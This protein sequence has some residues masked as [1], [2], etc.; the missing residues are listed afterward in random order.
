MASR[1]Q[2]SIRQADADY[3]LRNANNQPPIGV[4]E[5]CKITAVVDFDRLRGKGQSG[6]LARW[7]GRGAATSKHPLHPPRPSLRHFLRPPQD[8][9]EPQP[10]QPAPTRSTFRASVSQRDRPEHTIVHRTVRRS[11][12]GP[13]CPTASSLSTFLPIARLAAEQTT[14][15]E[16]TIFDMPVHSFMLAPLNVVVADHSLNDLHAESSRSNRKLNIA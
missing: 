16:A 14:Y 11:R 9:T 4:H 2:G 10:V 6:S 15:S 1:L 12:L 7:P 5:V 3:Q 8:W 13:P